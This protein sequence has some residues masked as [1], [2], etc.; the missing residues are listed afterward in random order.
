MNY[1][2]EKA[3]KERVND[4]EL[5]LLT[6]VYVDEDGLVGVSW[7]LYPDEDTARCVI[8]VSITTYENTF[9]NFKVV[10]DD[11]RETVLEYGENQ[12]TATY[13]IR[14]VK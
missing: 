6:C 2:I 8:D 10:V 13:K 12:V 3:I 9:D 7:F 14:K 11:D 5:Y 4:E 1:E